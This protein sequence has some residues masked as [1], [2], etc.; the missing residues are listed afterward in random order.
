MEFREELVELVKASVS[1]F[2][3]DSNYYADMFDIVAGQHGLSQEEADTL[4]SEIEDEL[5]EEYFTC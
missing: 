4:W 3:S 2:G 5:P 1:S